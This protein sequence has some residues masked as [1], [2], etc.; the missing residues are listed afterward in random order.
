M[1]NNLTSSEQLGRAQR[2]S[3]GHQLVEE[4]E[5]ASH[6]ISLA[7]R[8]GPS[9]QQRCSTAPVTRSLRSAVVI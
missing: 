6:L 4:L 3:Q 5:G 2:L 7:P 8:P 1:H 9:G